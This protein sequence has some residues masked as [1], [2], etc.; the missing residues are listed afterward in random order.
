MRNDKPL[1]GNCVNSNVQPSVSITVQSKGMI[2]FEF[3]DLDLD[4]HLVEVF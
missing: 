2:G 1:C 3:I 4:L